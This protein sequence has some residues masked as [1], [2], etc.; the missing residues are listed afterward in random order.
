MTSIQ[1]IDCAGL[2]CEP[3]REDCVFA[4]RFGTNLLIRYYEIIRR[5]MLAG[6]ILLLTF[7]CASRDELASL[8][9]SLRATETVVSEHTTALAAIKASTK[10]IELPE[11]P[12][13][14]EVISSETE[15]QPVQEGNGSQTTNSQPETT[16]AVRLFVTHAPFRCPPCDAF[17]RAVARGDLANFDVVKSE[18]FDGLESYPAIR[19]KDDSSPT[20]WRVRYGWSAGQLKWLKDNLLPENNAISSCTPEVST[21]MSHSE[22][23]ALHDSLHGGNF[24]W[25]WPGG[26]AESLAEHLRTTHGVTVD[27][28]QNYRASAIISPRTTVQVNTRRRGDYW[29]TRFPY[30]QSCP[31]GRCP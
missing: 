11:S 23:K 2:Y 1:V 17:D 15:P 8:K 10:A 16:A 29:R 7:G 6:F 19:F 12:I 22:M 24:S 30:R 5:L 25:T 3:H 14:T 4:S 20:G 18:G 27:V 21:A 13:G 9:Q 31:S 26:T 28:D